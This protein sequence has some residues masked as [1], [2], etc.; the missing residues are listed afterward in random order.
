VGAGRGRL[1][2]DDAVGVLRHVRSGK[3][4]R[5][6]VRGASGARVVGIAGV[7]I[8]FPLPTTDLT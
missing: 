7:I 3:R 1:P 8:R 5:E 2:G 4:V 6:C